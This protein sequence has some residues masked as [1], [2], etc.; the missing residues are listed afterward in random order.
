MFSVV[1]VGGG[2][3]GS[4]AAKWV[5]DISDSSAGKVALVGEGEPKNKKECEIFGAWFDEG[6]ITR[7][8]DRKD[9]WRLLAE[10]SIRRYRE[11]E[12]KSGVSFYHEVGFLSLF[13]DKF[14]SK[15][16]LED[17]VNIIR[18]S[19][20]ECDL[21]DSSCAPEIF[22]D[23]K[24]PDNVF[25]YYQPD[26][27][28]YI[29]PRELVKAQQVLAESKGCTIIDAAVKEV[30]KEEDKYRL[31]L[32]NGEIIR[33]SKVLL[34][35][36]AYL[37]LSK[38]LQHFFTTEASLKLTTQTVAYLRISEEEANRLAYLPTL[39][40]SYTSGALDGTYILPPIKYPDG[41]FYLKLGHHDAFEGE[42]ETVEEV[43]DWYRNGS[44]DNE[45]VTELAAF[46]QNFI[47]DLK[48]ESVS[49]GCC[50]TAKTPTK[51][52]PYIDEITDGLFVAAGG[53]GYAA[54]SCDEIGRIAA[55]LVV[56]GR[57]DS[58]IEQDRMKVIWKTT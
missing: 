31:S 42:V 48:V 56:E 47:K 32:S 58:D 17:A 29:N 23:I 12:K 13:D 10:K 41:R 36:G 51:D 25:G 16:D 21:V 6:R 3:I 40:T 38:H 5:A 34:A 8:L 24:L 54:K 19:G 46:L 43:L 7:I 39:V 33:A 55:V 53:C 20:Y 44:G 26:Y 52:A 30:I 1:V 4:S 45:A 9:S 11:I 37:N 50:V 27:S 18:E 14:K 2:M 49:G 15:T 28:G 57:W 22:P 35:T